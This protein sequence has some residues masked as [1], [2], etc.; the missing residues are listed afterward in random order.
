MPSRPGGP[1]F[2]AE[3]GP[4]LLIALVVV[5]FLSFFLNIVAHVSSNRTSRTITQLREPPLQLLD[6]HKWVAPRE[7]EPAA[8][9]ADFAPH[10]LVS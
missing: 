3:S 5:V 2:S 10:D 8:K 6:K 4:S 1:A 9:Q 7:A